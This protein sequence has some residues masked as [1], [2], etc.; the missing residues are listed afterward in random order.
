MSEATEAPLVRGD[1]C[2]DL[3][4]A[5]EAAGRPS[6]AP[7]AY[8]RALDSYEH[9]RVDALARRTRQRLAALPSE[10]AHSP[11]P[12]TASRATMAAPGA[13]PRRPR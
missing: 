4:V 6:E 2:F 9:K 13:Q 12:H 8:R 1:A 10:S 5:L 3:G 11:M 7:G